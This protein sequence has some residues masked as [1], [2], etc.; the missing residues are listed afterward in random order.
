M[1]HILIKTCHKRQK[2]IHRIKIIHEHQH[3]QTTL[4][5][6]NQ[7]NNVILPIRKDG[8]RG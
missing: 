2:I 7:I 3:N 5:D 4:R 1:E 8:R 6:D